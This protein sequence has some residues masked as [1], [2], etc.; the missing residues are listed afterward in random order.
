M[1]NLPEKNARRL[2][3]Q[4]RNNMAEEIKA[5]ES[6][7][8]ET[9]HD[10]RLKKQ[11]EHFLLEL[12]DCMG[13]ITIAC[14]KQEIARST[15]YNWCSSDSDFK[16]QV[17]EIKKEQIGVVEDRL[18]KAILQGNVSAIIFYLKCKHPEFKPKS[19]IT[20]DREKVDES[21]DTIK[22]IIEQK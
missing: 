1:R 5:I 13:I 7:S 2:M 11:K 15:F 3:N 9:P 21:L 16:K 19:E 18:L 20:F 17:D 4:N 14:E 10:K 22:K 6:K 8:V 12:R